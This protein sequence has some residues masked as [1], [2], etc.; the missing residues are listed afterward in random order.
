MEAKVE[1]ASDKHQQYSYR[2]RLHTS[3][4]LVRTLVPESC[5]GRLISVA[6]VTSDPALDSRNRDEAMSGRGL[7][8]P[9]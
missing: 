7:N 3:E 1:A 6:V 8:E 9:P 4:K 2:L 5:I